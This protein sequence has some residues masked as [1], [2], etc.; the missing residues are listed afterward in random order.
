[1]DWSENSTDMCSSFTGPTFATLDKAAADF[2]GK[3]NTS[4][5]LTYCKQN[6]LNCKAAQYANS[7]TTAGTNAGDWYLPS[8][9]ELNALSAV[10][11]FLNLSLA[12][13]NGS[14]ILSFDAR[15]GSSTLT[16]ECNYLWGFNMEA[17]TIAKTSVGYASGIYVRPVL[18]F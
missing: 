16:S 10:R 6:N 11:G 4:K 13:I 3:N 5:I 7:Y 9:G 12:K 14:Q 15:Y 2:D 1:M 18:A 8:A 17:G